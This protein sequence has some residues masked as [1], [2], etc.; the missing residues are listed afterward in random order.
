[1]S[2]GQRNFS[3]GCSYISQFTF[4][5]LLNIQCKHPEYGWKRVQRL[6]CIGV[7]HTLRGNNKNKRLLIVIPIGCVFLQ[8][9][10]MCIM[11]IQVF[12]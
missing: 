1:M 7:S 2:A 11:E 10:G 5:L 9:T 4:R 12:L 3:Q 6:Q 8:P